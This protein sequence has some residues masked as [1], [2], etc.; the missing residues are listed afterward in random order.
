M[1]TGYL[2]D[3]GLD[4]QFLIERLGVGHARGLQDGGLGVEPLQFAVDEVDTDQLRLGIFREIVRFVFFVIYRN[5][6]HFHF[7]FK[8][9]PRP[10]LGDG[11]LLDLWFLVGI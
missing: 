2:V 1:A 11:V 7:S 6:R 4:V 5:G 9:K 8:R 10:F 3:G